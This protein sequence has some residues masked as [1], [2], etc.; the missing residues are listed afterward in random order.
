M[1]TKKDILKEQSRILHIINERL[2][3]IE[4]I[5]KIEE[6]KLHLINK[7]EIIHEELSLI[8]KAITREKEKE[9]YNQVIIYDEGTIQENKPI[10]EEMEKT[11][12]G[13]MTGK[14]Q[15]K[16]KVCNKKIEHP[17]RGMCLN[18]YRKNT[19]LSKSK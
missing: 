5:S 16:C 18:C 14:T 15:I 12:K 1:E 2:K 3:S 9:K 8:K 11:K 6:D 19:G 10:E 13:K 17:R 4:A 7:W